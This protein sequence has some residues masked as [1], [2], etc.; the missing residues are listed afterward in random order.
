VYVPVPTAQRISF[1]VFELDRQTG[2][3][4]KHGTKLKLQGQP[5]AVLALLLER[6]GEL[7][8]REEIRK[9]LWPEDTFVD[10]EH[11][12]NTHIKKLRQVFDDDAETPRYIETLPRRG[13]RFV[14]QVEATPNGDVVV[15][16]AESAP[17]QAPKLR[18]WKY[19]TT[20]AVVLGVA[21]AALYWVNR[22]RTPVV[23]GIHQLTRTGHPKGFTF[24]MQQ[25]VTDG[26]RIYFP[27]GTL[28]HGRPI[29]IAQVS[30]KGGEVSYLELSS[31][32]LPNL[33]GG[34]AGGTE[35]LVIDL[36]PGDIEGPVSL[37]AMPSGTPRKLGDVTA[38]FAA[39]FP[40]G[41]R[42]L[43][44]RGSQL[45]RLQVAD[46]T[47]GGTRSILDVPY[48][49]SRLAVSPDG[50]RIRFDMSDRI[51]EATPDG[52][53]LHRIL[54]QI[55]GSLC[56][57]G[58]SPGGEFYA[59]GRLEDGIYNLWAVP[60]TQRWGTSPASTPIQLTFGPIS[61]G[62][63]AFSPD[64]R[65][66]FAIGKVLRG[67]LSVYD[68]STKQFQPYLSGVSA[69]YLDSSPDGQ[70]V[71]YVTYPQSTLWRS[72]ADGSERMQ[73]TFPPMGPVLNPKWSPDG[74]LIAF[75]EW[76]TAEK[77]V[78][79]VP[80]SG[81]DPLLLL[82]GNFNP[83]DPTWSPDG[84]SIAYSGVSTQDGTGTEVRIL[85]LPTKQSRAVH[86]SQHM[87]SARWSPDGRYLVALSDD[88]Q[89]LFLYTF[90]TGHWSELQSPGPGSG[91]PVWSHG[92]PYLYVMKGS[93]V[94]RLHVPDGGV[95]LVVDASPIEMTNPTFPSIPWFG[96][97]A[98]DRVVV[99]RDRGSDELYALDV[100]YRR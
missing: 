29:R 25:V 19:A 74:K 47:G 4:F 32:H 51:W 64:G 17:T 88:F 85:D 52:A 21:A 46:L 18:R 55:A 30:I 44:N 10:F 12:L 5:I 91:G 69:G 94:Y 72:R 90:E 59:F 23:T 84:K 42:L 28:G 49:A 99:L 13:Y 62:E 38:T 70:W 100:D 57:G 37:V 81:G 27:E 87:F 31:L 11:S 16:D 1:G 82:S 50:A 58:W 9:H 3:L 20:A 26:T 63:P 40:D 66:I 80:S 60:E 48:A 68:K 14:A 61:F 34:F 53:G 75:T 6:P 22:P 54:P 98:D 73:L 77:K 41:K 76:G 2:E 93:G 24:A 8:T 15:A 89:K 96:L 45:T 36:F 71:A 35:L 33:D 97:T 65:Q 39:L 79:I 56:C 95:E 43:F 92:G 78:Y 83:S 7:V 86:G 67:E